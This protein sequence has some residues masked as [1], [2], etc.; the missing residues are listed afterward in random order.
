MTTPTLSLD[1]RPWF[2]LQVE[3]HKRFLAAFKDAIPTRAWDGEAREP[4]IAA[5]V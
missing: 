5:P 2:R 4:N 1:D 3:Y